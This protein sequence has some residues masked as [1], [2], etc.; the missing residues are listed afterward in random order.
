MKLRNKKTGEIYSAW[1][2]RI[3]EEEITSV[4][5]FNDTFEDY[6]PKEPLLTEKA[7][8]ILRDWAELNGLEKEIFHCTCINDETMTFVIWKMPSARGFEFDVPKTHASARIT[9]GTE[10]TLD[11]LCGEE[12]ASEPL[13]PRFIDLDERIREKEGEK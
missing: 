11:Q 2:I 4:E 10:Y 1:S 8:R 5:Q 3:G 7:A 6:K 9:V 12:E 13:E